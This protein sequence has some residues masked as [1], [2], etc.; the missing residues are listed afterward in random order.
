VKYLLDTNVVS[1]A[2]KPAG[3]PRVR[4]M[5]AEINDTDLFLSVVSI[6]EIA[7]GIARLQTSA[8]RTQ[9]QRWLRDTERVFADRVLPITIDI[10]R[11]WGELTANAASSGRVIP[12]SDGLIA[13]TALH[14][15][16]TLMTRNI[17]DFTATGVTL[18]DPW[19]TTT[20]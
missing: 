8:K 10:A 5:L 14:H 7:N 18:I 12:V 3:S 9:L 6:G 11:V 16:L 4:A 19:Q 15:G 1:E 20:T 2:Q 17:A 13:A